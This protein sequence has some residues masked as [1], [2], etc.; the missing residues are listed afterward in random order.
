[1]ILGLDTARGGPILRGTDRDGVLAGA[2][3]MPVGQDLGTVAVGM[4]LGMA[5]HGAGVAV[6]IA[7]AATG[8]IIIIMQLRIRN[9]MADVPLG[10]EAM[11]AQALRADVVRMAEA[12]QAATVL[13]LLLYEMVLR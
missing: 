8:D 1:M 10:A 6:T 3:F 12:M 4:I 7:V 2:D 9:I 11:Q 5:R 13:H